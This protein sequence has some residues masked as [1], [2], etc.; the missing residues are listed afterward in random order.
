RSGAGSREERRTPGA[1]ARLRAERRRALAAGPGGGS[2]G[3]AGAPAPV[4][5][6]GR[7]RERLR[8]VD[9]RELQVAPAATPGAVSRWSGGAWAGALSDASGESRHR[10]RGADTHGLR[11]LAPGPLRA[12]ARAP[13]SRAPPAARAPRAGPAA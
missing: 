9:H 7:V 11:Q 8:G 3:R 13:R 2:A 4:L 1:R 5:R 10:A 12:A 6:G